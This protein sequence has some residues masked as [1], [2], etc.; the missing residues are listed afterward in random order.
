MATFRY[1]VYRTDINNTIVRESD[2]AGTTGVNEDELFTD[3]II[4]EIQPLYL[5]RVNIGAG[6][7]EINDESSINTYLNEINPI[8]GDSEVIYEV[9]TGYTG[10]TDTRLIGIENDLS[11]NQNDIIF[12]SGETASKIDKVTGATGNFGTFDA[13]GNLI[14]SGVSAGD[15][16][17]DITQAEF[18]GYTGAT[19]TRLEG[20]ES[21]ITFLSGETDTKLATTLFNTYTGDT[22]TELDL[23]IT[24]GT[25]GLTKVGRNL[26]LGGELSQSTTI[27]NSANTIT[28]NGQPIKY[29]GSYNFGALD[30]IT[31][32]YVDGVASGL[33]VKDSVR[34]ATSSGD[35]DIDLTG[36]AFGG[37]IDGV[38]VADGDRVLVKNQDTNPE[39]N[40]IYV[41]QS[42]TSTF[43]RSIDADEDAEVTSGLFAFVEEGNTNASSGWVITS[44]NPI[45]VGT[46]PITFTIFSS[47]GEFIGGTGIN[48]ANKTISLD[49]AAVAGNF[50]EFT[51]GELNVIDLTS[52][53]DFNIY[54]GATDSRLGDIELDITNLESDVL[55]L[56]GQTQNKLETSVFEAYTGS[57]QVNELQLYKTDATEVNNIIPTALDFDVVQYSGDSFNYTGGSIIKILESGDY[58][59]SYNIPIRNNDNNEKSLGSNIIKNNNIVVGETGSALSIV[60]GSGNSNILALSQVKVTLAANDNLELAIF[61][62]GNT[63]S[64]LTIPESSTIRIR[65]AGTLD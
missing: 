34:L 1:L 20:I 52:Q 10:T 8:D 6:D 56:S 28:F 48:I 18:D 46:T 61:R 17:G 32:E 22:R 24:G 14:D 44:V 51:G 31:K 33:D 21:D 23:T 39:Q 5:Y 9:F 2:T 37:T 4:P 65:K 3:F 15:I 50:L 49:G 62:N 45:T 35:T 25:N 58:V 40:G 63:G 64:A 43:T 27:V 60:K 47:A 7:V 19:D 16:S 29:A 42:A 53:V 26:R 12:L 54:S 59:V 30:L 36:G 55:S 57:T 41:Y 11:T 38:S 13:T